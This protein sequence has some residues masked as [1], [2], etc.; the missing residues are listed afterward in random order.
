M[1]HSKR[2]HSHRGFS[3]IELL[4]VVVI[5]SLVYAIGF[6]NFKIRKATPKALT[7]LNLKETIVKSEFFNGHATLMCVNKCRNCYLRQGISSA[8]KAYSNKI[9]L[10]NIKAYTVDERESLRRLEYE[11]Y[12]DKK[13]CLVM[14]FYNNGSSTQIILEDDKGAYFL[15]AF[16]GEPKRFDSPDDAKT[17]WLEKSHSVSNS[18]EYY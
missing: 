15:P 12:D 5:I 3:L 1:P 7:P 6:S 11:R 10:T 2:Y 13:I 16:F 4:I 18:G 8:F 17:Y 9:D 14:D